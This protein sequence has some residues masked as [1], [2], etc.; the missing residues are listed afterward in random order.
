VAEA[1]VREREVVVV[2]GERRGAAQAVFEVVPPRIA[3]CARMRS[4]SRFRPPDG[5]AAPMPLR[6]R[7]GAANQRLRLPAAAEA[8]VREREVVV[9]QGEGEGAAQ[10][11]LEVV[12]RAAADRVGARDALGGP[13]ADVA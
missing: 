10:A 8:D 13:L 6:G 5:S 2:Q 1:D 7:G 9:G 11:V 12:R 4:M 3:V